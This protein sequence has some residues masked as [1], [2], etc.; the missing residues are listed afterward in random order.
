M[1]ELWNRK[2][3]ILIT[4]QWLVNQANSIF[5]RGWLTKTELEEI[6]K[7]TELDNGNKN[8][9]DP[10]VTPQEA[11][12]TGMESKNHLMKRKNRFLKG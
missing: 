1:L 9:T 7:K 12:T 11:N 5:K 8:N 6:T 2:G 10:D 3:L 4:D